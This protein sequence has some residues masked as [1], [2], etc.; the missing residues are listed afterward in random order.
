MIEGSICICE[1]SFCD[2]CLVDCKLDEVRRIV[3][4]EREFDVDGKVWGDDLS[5]I[6]GGEQ[7]FRFCLLNFCLLIQYFV[8][9]MSMIQVC[10][11]KIW[12]LGGIRNL[13]YI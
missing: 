6:T 8:Q 9:A 3:L 4:E 13:R 5:S 2:G 11:W 1:C 10:D 12:D 7:N